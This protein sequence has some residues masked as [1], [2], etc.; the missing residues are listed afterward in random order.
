[1]SPWVYTYLCYS[2]RGS[3]LLLGIFLGGDK[4]LAYD[5]MGNV[6]VSDKTIVLSVFVRLPILTKKI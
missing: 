2:M 5:A 1:M 4:Y 3:R 6:S